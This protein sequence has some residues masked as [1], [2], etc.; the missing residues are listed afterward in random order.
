MYCWFPPTQFLEQ[1]IALNFYIFNTFKGYALDYDKFDDPN[2]NPFETK[3]AMSN[4]PPPSAVSKP[5]PLD[6]PNFNPFQSKK[7]M[8]N[9]PPSTPTQFDNTPPKVPKP[10]AIK[11]LPNENDEAKEDNFQVILNFHISRI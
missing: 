8:Q 7:Q 4:S 2:F 11:I 5:D 3:K 1:K 10:E 6:D 9:S